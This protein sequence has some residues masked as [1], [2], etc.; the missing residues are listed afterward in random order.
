VREADLVDDADVATVEGTTVRIDLDGGATVNGANIVA[1]D[2]ETENGVI[3]LI[4]EVLIGSLDL[5]DQAVLYGFDSLV[6]AVQ[7]AGLEATLRGDN[8]G[9]GYTVFAPTNEAFADIAPLPTDVNVLSDIL[10]YHVLPLTAE[11]SGLSDGQVVATAQG[12][13]PR[14]DG[15]EDLIELAVLHHGQAVSEVDDALIV[16]EAILLRRREGDAE[17]ALPELLG[18]WGRAPVG[19]EQ[20]V[21]L[22]QGV[23][24]AA[25]AA[26]LGALRPPG[27]DQRLV[28]LGEGREPVLDELHDVPGHVAAAEG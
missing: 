24:P 5:V 20:G 13:G 3:H 26:I 25:H 16:G 23:A 19:R 17:P 4:D 2:V 21:G 15:V 1:T 11:S 8:M 6:G 18:G 28:G 9:A 27:V 22:A 10:L 14:V 12:S 7:T